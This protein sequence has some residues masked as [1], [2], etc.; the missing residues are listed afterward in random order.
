[1]SVRR[2]A[3]KAKANSHSHAQADEWASLSED[4]IANINTLERPTKLIAVVGMWLLGGPWI[5]GL[6]FALWKLF[7]EERVDLA[8]LVV[9]GLVL[10]VILYR[11]T[12]NYVLRRQIAKARR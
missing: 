12:R 3:K 8:F 10:S 4:E 2:K 11:T 6:P 9:M 1:V 5:I 7:T